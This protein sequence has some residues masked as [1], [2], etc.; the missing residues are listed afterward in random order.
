[1]TSENAQ[2]T[3]LG[4]VEA[5]TASPA[6]QNVAVQWL[7]QS[8][9]DVSIPAMSAYGSD[10]A[11][12]PSELIVDACRALRDGPATAFEMLVDV[13]ANDLLPRM[14]RWEVVYNFLSLARNERF[15]LKVEVEDGPDPVVPSVSSVYLSAN[16]YEREIYDLMGIRF[17]AHP[18]LTRILLPEDWQGYPLRFDH[19]LGGEE[20]GFTS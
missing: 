11:V 2:A 13:T 19:P 17:S 4:Q 5:V 8:F 12:V 6:E 3:A 10:W 9:P 14:P 7:R 18:D 20:V 16:W 1:V 15:R